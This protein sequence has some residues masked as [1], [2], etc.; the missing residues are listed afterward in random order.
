[1]TKKNQ[2]GGK[3]WVLKYQTVWLDSVVTYKKKISG[4]KERKRNKN[5][6][7]IKRAE[8]CREPGDNQIALFLYTSLTVGAER[9]IAG[10][11]VKELED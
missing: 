1:M 11:P 3:Y 10:L 6:T 7:R 5:R 8:R 2:R 9:Q 4:K